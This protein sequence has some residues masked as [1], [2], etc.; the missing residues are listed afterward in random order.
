MNEQKAKSYLSSALADNLYIDGFNKKVGNVY[1]FFVK[2]KKYKDDDF[3]LP[4]NF[5]VREDGEILDMDGV[6][7]YLDELGID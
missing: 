7:D 5:G 2:D 3:V 1:L 6:I 4:E